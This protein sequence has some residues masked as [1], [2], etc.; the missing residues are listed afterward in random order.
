ME[1]FKIGVLRTNVRAITR[2]SLPWLQ[3]YGNLAA[4]FK[5]KLFCSGNN[6]NDQISTSIIVMVI[7]NAR[8]FLVGIVINRARHRSKMTSI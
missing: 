3:R 7:E 5:S 1:G 2:T 6:N 4:W 8:C